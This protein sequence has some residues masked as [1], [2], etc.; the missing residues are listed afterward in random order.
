M[1][2]VIQYDNAMPAVRGQ[3]GGLVK[4]LWLDGHGMCLLSAPHPAST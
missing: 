2:A 3:R 1:Y 4:V